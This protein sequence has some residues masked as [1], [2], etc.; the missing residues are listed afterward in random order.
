MKFILIH[1][2]LV[3]P[4]TWYTVARSL[5]ER[6]HTTIIPRLLDNADIT[7]PY[8]QQE[9]SSI[10]DQVELQTLYPPTILVVHSGAGPLLPA[11]IDALNQQ[12]ALCVFVDAGLPS[13]GSQCR[14]DL[15][16]AEDDEWA[17]AFEAELKLGAT[18]PNWTD[19]QLAT[20]IPDAAIRQKL[21]DDVQPHGTGFYT[22]PIP[23]PDRWKSVPCA[24]LG[25][26]ETY[27]PYFEK[28]TQ[29][30][31]QTR[32]IAAHHFYMLTNPTEVSDTLIA[33]SNAILEP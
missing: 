28:A 2:P 20:I 14:L 9:V 29:Q 26:S 25:F 19:E 13:E 31:W 6:G 4:F 22:E 32:W 17:A 16:Y 24:Y 12:I 23:T 21:I 27:R 7:A 15:M 10:V 33:F 18:Y 5:Q 30:S 11:I 3:G 8:W 1:S